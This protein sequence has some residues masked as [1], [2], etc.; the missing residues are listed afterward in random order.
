ME[1]TLFY[2]AIAITLGFVLHP[3]LNNLISNKKNT[4][5]WTVI[6]RKSKALSI[7][8]SRNKC[9]YPDRVTGLEVRKSFIESVNKRISFE[10]N[11]DGMF[12]I[13]A[14]NINNFV[15]V[16]DTYGYQKGDETLKD[17]GVRI[18]GTLE[19]LDDYALSRPDSNT[20]VL[21]APVKHDESEIYQLAEEIL[22]QIRKPILINET[23][24]RLTASIG[25]AN[26]PFDADTADKL[27][28]T[29][30]KAVKHAS[31]QGGD[32]ISIY[33]SIGKY[34]QSDKLDIESDLYQAL[35]R[36]ELELRFQPIFNVEQNRVVAAE[37]LLRWKREGVYVS[38]ADFI[39]VAEKT[40]LILLIGSWVLR[41]ACEMALRFINEG[42]VDNDFVISVNVSVKQ[43][44][45]GHFD[46]ELI[47]VI[48]EVGL[49]SRNIQIEITETYHTSEEVIKE[50]LKVIAGFG[51][52]IVLDDFGT[53]YSNLSY[54]SELCVSGLKIDRMFIDNLTK[55]DKGSLLIGAFTEIANSLSLDLVAEGVEN[56]EQLNILKRYGIKLI[57]GYL[58]S[59]PLSIE[60]F[61]EI[62]KRSVAA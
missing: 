56:E 58:K 30:Q 50:Q 16:N 4:A 33:D 11:N 31:A 14:I 18:K 15:Y 19:A 60:Q 36:N 20:F 8:A 12:G 28:N 23:T 22:K 24:V 46:R 45:L 49:P 13:I 57:Q 43:F 54:L 29:A 51:V 59:Y 6:Y 48:Q 10:V 21:I 39:P 61:Y 34:F 47:K 3:I 1:I 52:K 41:K 2:I 17:M 42:V 35:E 27:I 5:I 32:Q 62:K 55:E 53:G 26:F 9:K 44:K 7:L 37:A 40:S 25:V 38:P